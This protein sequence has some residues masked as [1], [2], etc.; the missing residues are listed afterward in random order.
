MATLTV[1]TRGQITFR[2]DVLEH[3]GIQPGGKIRLNLLPDGKAELEA[4]K[5]QGSWQELS[6]VLKNKTNGLRLSLEELDDAIAE[7][8]AAA[9]H[10]G[11]RHE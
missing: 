1:T 11:L 4:D 10:G 7:A 5:G 3:L 2:K 8:G 6:G 9:G